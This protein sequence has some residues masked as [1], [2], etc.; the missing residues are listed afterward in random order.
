MRGL[1][2]G[3]VTFLFTDIEGS[4]RLLHE[5]GDAY[6]EEL[7]RHRRVLRDAFERHGGVEVD[8]Q[9]DAFFVAFTRA[10]DALAAAR[11]GQEALASGAVRVRMGVHTGEPIVTDEGY[12]GL[13]V[14]RAAR[15]AAIGHGGQVLV[16]RS[17]RDLAAIDALRDLGEHRLKDLTAPERIYQLGDAEFP[18][19]RSLNQTNLPIQATPLIGREKELQESL[20]LLDSTPLLTLT[21]TGGT[22]KT[23]LALQAAAEVVDEYPDGVWFV[24]L[25]ALT[26]PTLIEATIASVVSATGG[27]GD[28]LRSKRVLLVLDNLEQ[29]LPGASAPIGTLLS[30][31]GVKVLATS[32]ERL[33]LS[34]EQELPVPPLPLDEAVALFVARARQ[35]VPEFQQDA[36][37]IEIARRLDGLPL[38]VELAAARVKVLT[39]Q[40]ML[41]RL[42]RSLDLLTGGARDQPERQQTLRATIQWSVE[43]LSPAEQDLFTRLAIFSG[44]FD[45]EAAEQV[46]DADIDSIQS[47]VDKS[48]LR[49]GKDA[50]FF[51]LQTIHQFAA[52]RSGVTTSATPFRKRHADWYVALADRLALQLQQDTPQQT[53]R[54]LDAELA[55]IRAALAWLSEI[56]PA[57]GLWVVSALWRYWRIRGLLNDALRWVDICWT[58]EAPEQTRLIALRLI[59]GVASE[60]ADVAK[61]RSTS[62]ERLELAR[63]AGAIGDQAGAFSGLGAAAQ[64]EGD[65]GEARRL[66]QRAIELAREDGEPTR[67]AL[68]I[69][70][71]GVIERLDGEVNR[72]RELLEESL[73]TFRANGPAASVAETVSDYAETLILQKSFSEASQAIREGLELMKEIGHAGWLPQALVVVASLAAATGRAEN[74]APLLGAAHKLEMAMDVHI[75]TPEQGSLYQPT[76]ERVRDMLGADRF[77]EAFQRGASLATDEALQ[78]ARST[79]A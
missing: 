42:G 31:A 79:L 5:L 15:I 55:N 34:A 32:R 67:V 51:M 38:A 7:A 22:G 30:A 14:H 28:F 25:A 75:L 56:D 76:L 2:T 61:L 57:T 50:R 39:P 62:Q 59:A 65:Y 46:V 33:G 16:S 77:A 52:G 72:S 12:V 1:P 58:D 18:R 6:A 36:D 48:L 69:H 19:L 43:L 41:Q 70:N 8:T 47:L 40:Q 60:R 13:A 78:L 73:A 53:L 35:L 63:S 68:L 64:F 71:L 29:L 17:T 11:E 3:T 9:G 74:A 23:R 24:S 66:V 10:S 45:L 20:R 21:G 4:T 26:D 49:R 27:L 37:V 44:S 54:L